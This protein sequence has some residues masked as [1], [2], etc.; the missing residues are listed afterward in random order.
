M[1]IVGFLC[2]INITTIICFGANLISYPFI[3]TIAIIDIMIVLA[4]LNKRGTAT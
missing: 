4:L 1:G 3:F 2:G